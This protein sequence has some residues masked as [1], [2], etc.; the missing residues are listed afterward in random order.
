MMFLI[1]SLIILVIVLLNV[2]VLIS[3]EL[4]NVGVHVLNLLF[5]RRHLVSVCYKLPE[6]Y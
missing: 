3:P 5:P 1:P 6:S 2:I 4:F